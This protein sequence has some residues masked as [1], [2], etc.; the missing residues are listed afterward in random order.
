MV[1]ISI[2]I[3]G[4]IIRMNISFILT[5]ETSTKVKHAGSS[6]LSR[7]PAPGLGG[8]WGFPKNRGTLLGVPIIRIIVD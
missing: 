3:A 1:T 6:H 8:T 5:R 2:T 4:T 7:D